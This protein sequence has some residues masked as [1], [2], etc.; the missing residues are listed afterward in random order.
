MESLLLDWRNNDY[1][2]NPK[3]CIWPIFTP[4]EPLASG[5]EESGYRILAPSASFGHGDEG[6]THL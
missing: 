2:T 5:V 6:L 1:D 4:S 3:I